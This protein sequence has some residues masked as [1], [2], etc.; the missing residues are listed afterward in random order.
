MHVQASDRRT[1]PKKWSFQTVP[2]GP[3]IGVWL[4]FT[5]T[6]IYKKEPF[7]KIDH[8]YPSFDVEVGQKIALRARF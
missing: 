7:K 5:L 2:M 4:E 8:K 6:K 1:C 3:T